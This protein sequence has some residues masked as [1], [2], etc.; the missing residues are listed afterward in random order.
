MDD[1]E[2]IELPEEGGRRKPLRPWNEGMQKHQGL[3]GE[4]YPDEVPKRTLGFL[5][6]DGHIQLLSEPGPE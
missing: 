2:N 6:N 4:H 5:Q 3:Q 1:A